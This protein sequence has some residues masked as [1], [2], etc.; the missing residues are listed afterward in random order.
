MSPGGALR[1]RRGPEGLVQGEG[2]P[3]GD[4]SASSGMSAVA[5]EETLTAVRGLLAGGEVTVD[6]AEVHLDR[7]R[8]D[9]V[10]SPVPPVLAGAQRQRSLALA[11]RVA[12]GVV[13]SGAGPRYVRWALEQAGR[14]GDFR[15]VTLA[16]ASVAADRREAYRMACD[17]VAELVGARWPSYTVLPFFDDLT[18]R[19]DD[20]GPRAPPGMPADYWIELDTVDTQDDAHQHVDALGRA[21]AEVVVVYPSGPL[22][23][24]TRRVALAADITPIP[25]V[26]DSLDAKAVAARLTLAQQKQSSP[27]T[28]ARRRR[29]RILVRTWASWP[30]PT[31]DSRTSAPPPH[32]RIDGMDSPGPVNERIRPRTDSYWPACVSRRSRLGASRRL[33]RTPRWVG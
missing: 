27:P 8:L 19:I 5:L 23:D 12:D 24:P 28:G 17:Q 2:S 20:D 4:G 18:H 15:V 26:D 32:P 7:V 22:D 6:G 21:D 13:L 9:C 10:P 14:P 33:P 30:V 1:A 3:V 11:G 25:A 31:T 16:V 29:T